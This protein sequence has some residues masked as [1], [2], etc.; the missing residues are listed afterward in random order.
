MTIYDMYLQLTS[1]TSVLN[2]DEISKQRL[3]AILFRLEFFSVTHGSDKIDSKI[4]EHVKNFELSSS[5][6]CEIESDLNAIDTFIAKS[7]SGTLS[8]SNSNNAGINHGGVTMNKVTKVLEIIFA[9]A[10][11][12]V[13]ILAIIFL[14][15]GLIE[16]INYD[17]LAFYI[18][19]GGAVLSLI[20]LLISIVINKHST[21]DERSATYEINNSFNGNK[22]TNIKADMQKGSVI[23]D[24]VNDNE[25]GDLHITQKRH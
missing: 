14:S 10:T 15:L 17:M 8:K 5:H 12:L 3:K 23:K 1:R 4:E 19:L 20:G 25:D 18:T 24:S 22:G 16:E 2:G 6:L 7:L 21:A 13:S 11:I 9:I